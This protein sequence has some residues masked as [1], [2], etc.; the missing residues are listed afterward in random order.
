MNTMTDAKN[1]ESGLGHSSGRLRMSA[2]EAFVETLIALHVEEVFGFAGALRFDVADSFRAAGARLVGAARA[3][4]ALQMADGYGRV[5]EQPAVCLVSGDTDFARLVTEVSSAYWARTPLIVVTAE[6]P[7]EQV[8]ALSK[9]T[10]WQGSATSP[11]EVAYVTHRAFAIAAHERGPVQLIL[12]DDC[13]RGEGEYEIRAPLVI[14]RAAGGTRSLARAAQLLA[15]A[16]FPVIVAGEDLGSGVEE[17]KALAE[18]LTAP[19]VSP[20]RRNDSFPASHPLACGPLGPHGSRAATQIV[21]RADI[22]LALG[23]RLGARAAEQA[24]ESWRENSKIIQ[25]DNDDRALGLAG[26]VA[27]AIHGD[28]RLAAQELLGYFKGRAVR[29][30]DKAR[31]AE[32]QREKETWAAALAAQPSPH[33]KGH[34]GARRALAQ[35]ARALPRNA[36]VATDVGQLCAMAASYLGFEQ[37]GS[38]LAAMSEESRGCA[39]P[40]ALGARLAQPGR[41]AIACVGDGAWALGNAELVTAVREKVPA[42]AVVL[43]DGQPGVEKGSP[44]D[45]SEDA[46]VLGAEGYCAEYEDE[47]ADALKAALRSGKP[48]VVEIRVTPERGDLPGREVRR[49]RRPVTAQ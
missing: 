46:R 49:A 3:A 37:S 7:D 40:I 47:I 2:R 32:V 16:K 36:M 27:L 25:V 35:L 18:H 19:V 20:Y 29:K 23:A 34:I 48:A 11:L 1:L 8:S 24:G 31:L 9:V 15:Q 39:Y 5:G 42:I 17:V 44:Q 13:F 38:F 33:R 45:L 30:P 12:G 21:S 22:V 26:E 43:N 41:P 14:E 10:R 4:S 6:L 28:A